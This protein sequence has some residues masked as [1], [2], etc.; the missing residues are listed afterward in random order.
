M[1]KITLEE[2]MTLGNTLEQER[3]FLEETAG[4]APE[5]LQAEL[6]IMAERRASRSKALD[7]SLRALVVEVP[8]ELEDSV[9]PARGA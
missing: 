8:E 2:A 5:S 4:R 1:G 3:R 9:A 7:T 6:R